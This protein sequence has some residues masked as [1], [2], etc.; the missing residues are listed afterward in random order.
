MAV[1]PI[2][3]IPNPILR[4]SS[5]KVTR[6]DSELKKLAQEMVETMRHYSGVGLAAP[7]VG[8]LVR[9]VVLEYEPTQKE[10]K[11]GTAR[12][13]PF[14]LIIL[15]NPKITRFSKEKVVMDEGCLSLPDLELKV[16]RPKEVNVSAQD[17]E[18]KKIKIRAKG[19]FAR[20]IQHEIDHLD[21]VLFTDRARGA[22]NIKNYGALRLVFMGTPDFALPAL[23]A[24]ATKGLPITGVITEPD[25]PVGRSQEITPSPVKRVAQE[26]GLPV[27][28]PKDN[29]EINNILKQLAPH[30]IVVVAYGR[31][32]SKEIFDIAPYGILNIHFSLLPQYRGAAPVQGALLAGEKEIGV[33]I[34][35]M[36]E[37]LD[38]GPVIWQEKYP[39][40][41]KDTA[42]ELYK[43]LSIEGA[44]LLVKTLPG[45]LSN[46]IQP[47]E[48][49]DSKATYKKSIK[50]EDGLISASD[51]TEVIDRKVRAYNPWPHAYVFVDNK[52][53]IIH[54]GHVENTKYVPELV[55]LEG[56]NPTNWEDFKR[57]FKGE[58]PGNLL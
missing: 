36:V 22:K 1:L 37:K 46:Q 31:I 2:L 28:Q 6:F 38:A 8:S 33:A 12:D 21:G 29:E 19:L 41:E 11:E 20:V 39:I 51:T 5:K 56:K 50:K 24:L 54:S 49:D 30:Y 57:G 55:Q 18:G 52:R 23:E 48:Q 15:V 53:L 7:Q 34:M 13:K 42:G 4:Q 9:M 16:E 27:F 58:L 25:K 47:K 43:R 45:Y 40:D 44:N 10:I 3:T 14:S 17:L 32:L 26:F 35:K